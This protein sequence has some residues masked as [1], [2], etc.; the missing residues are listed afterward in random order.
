MSE[1]DEV[2]V[3]TAEWL[4]IK[5]G[6]DPTEMREELYGLILKFHC[7]VMPPG[8]WTKVTLTE[9]EEAGVVWG[10]KIIGR[11][12]EGWGDKGWTPGKFT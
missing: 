6:G 9:L 10:V 5:A 8:D 12:G 2:Y 4:K 11:R 3:N 7:L 1:I